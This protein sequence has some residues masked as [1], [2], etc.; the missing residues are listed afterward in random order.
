MSRRVCASPYLCEALAHGGAPGVAR[1]RA[2]TCQPAFKVLSPFV[3]AIATANMFA[4]PFL[5]ACIYMRA[6]ADGGR[7][8]KGRQDAPGSEKQ[9]GIDLE[10]AKRSRMVY[11]MLRY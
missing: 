7:V 2:L 1:Q 4:E 9:T 11:E 6:S 8:Q 5:C 10:S 3:G